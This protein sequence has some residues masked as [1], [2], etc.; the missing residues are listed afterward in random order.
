[1]PFREA[2]YVERGS[3]GRKMGLKRG[4]IFRSDFPRIFHFAKFDGGNEKNL[5]H[6]FSTLHFAEGRF[7]P[8]PMGVKK[9]VPKRVP[10]VGRFPFPD[11][12]FPFPYLPL[13]SCLSELSNAWKRTNTPDMMLAMFR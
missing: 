13:W 6:V 9:Q 5:F 10:C 11:C 3:E 8:S 2:F 7:S 12:Y 1:M 4:W